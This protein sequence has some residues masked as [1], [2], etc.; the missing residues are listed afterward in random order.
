MISFVFRETLQGKCLLLTAESLMLGKQ[1]E[2]CPKS[3]S[4]DVAGVGEGR[5]LVFHSATQLVTQAQRQ[6]GI[7]RQ[8]LC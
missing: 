2:T 6:R 7:H 5:E 8:H 1:E 4:S 3:P